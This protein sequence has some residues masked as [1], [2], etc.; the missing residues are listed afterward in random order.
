L[1]RQLIELEDEGLIRRSEPQRFHKRDGSFGSSVIYT[2]TFLGRMK[3]L[4]TKKK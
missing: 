3:E 4:K 2:V 1:S